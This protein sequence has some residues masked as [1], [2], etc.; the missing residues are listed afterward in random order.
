VIYHFLGTEPKNKKRDITT[1]IH[2]GIIHNSRIRQTTLEGSRTHQ[3]EGEAG[4]PPGGAGQPH[5]TGWPA[6]YEGNP[7]HPSGIFF[8]HP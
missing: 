5:L 6:S 8:H 1:N 7:L 2:H 3:S 4:P